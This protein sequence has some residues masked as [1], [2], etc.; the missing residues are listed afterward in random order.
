MQSK[1]LIPMHQFI[2]EIDFMSTS[3]FCDTYGVPHPYFTGDV[4]SSA[5]KF[6]QVD[7][8]KH[9]IFVEYAK[10][11]NKPLTTEILLKL[12]GF[13]AVDIR[14]GN[15]KYKQGQYVIE[16]DEF[17]Y[18]LE[19]Y[20]SVDGLRIHKVNDLVFLNISHNIHIQ[21]GY[22]RQKP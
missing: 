7:A 1:T 12:L 11:L 22:V 4:Q 18:W 15:E 9:K 14:A 3:E 16:N 13:E 10:F 20:G 17:G 21:N 5:D 6:L 8:I 19:P 2:L